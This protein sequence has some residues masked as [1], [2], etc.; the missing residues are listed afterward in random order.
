MDMFLASVA[1]C[2]KTP[3][4]PPNLIIQW[5][6]VGWIGGHSSL[7]MRSWQINLVKHWNILSLSKNSANFKGGYFFDSRCRVSGPQINTSITDDIRV[8]DTRSRRVSFDRYRHILKVTFNILL[9][10][11]GTCVNTMLIVVTQQWME[12]V[13]LCTWRDS[14]KNTIVAS[15]VTKVNITVFPQKTNDL[16]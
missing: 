13:E 6:K 1:A 3:A 10:E 4:L 12:P 5:T 16:S 14:D 15:G 7:A 2:D 11:R 8:P 9:A